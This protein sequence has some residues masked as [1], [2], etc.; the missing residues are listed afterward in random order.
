M[1]VKLKRNPDPQ[2]VEELIRW[3]EGQHL[4]VH[5]SMGEEFTILGLVGDT[6]K[7][8]E[9]LIRALDI[10]SD[11]K[12]IQEPYKDVNREFHPQ[13][14]V[15]TLDNGTKIGGG[16]FVIIAGPCSVESK[17]Q[18][19]NLA[20]ECQQAGATVLRGGAFKPRTSPYSFQGMGTSGLD[21]L[22]LAREA[23]GLPIISEIMETS[24]LP[25]FEDIDILQVGARN[26]QNFEL[27]KAIGRTK[28][29]VM[30]KR[31][32][33][34]TYEEWLMSAEYVMAGGNPNVLLCER[35]IRTYE[36]AVR[37]T[38]DVTAFPFLHEKTHLP[39]VADPSH[40]AGMWRMVPSLSLSAIA[41]GADSL[42]VEVHNDPQHAL[43]D[44][45][46]AL[47]PS[48]F[49]RLAEEVMALRSFLVQ[50]KKGE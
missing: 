1:I 44:G 16:N 9:D 7:V 49:A 14:T 50:R 5:S 24:Q 47:K 31:G 8:D 12:R 15:I 46:Q 35:G 2:Q 13:D 18:I 11:V 27:L 40:A 48:T 20:K 3:L 39:I 33:S 25:Y 32:L 26:M 19:V 22:R 4:T 30:I 6:S 21:L 17:E 38:F 41:A 28:K 42:M 10:V 45:P 34:A 43:S 36:T 23:T 37:N 29:P